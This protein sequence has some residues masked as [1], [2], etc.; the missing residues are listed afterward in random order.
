MQKN[1]HQ[2]LSM[3]WGK[4]PLPPLAEVTERALHAEETN[5]NNMVAD[6]LLPLAVM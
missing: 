6:N 3:D 5:A 1:S 2:V 4:A